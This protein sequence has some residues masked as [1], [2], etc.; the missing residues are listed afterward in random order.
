M[1]VLADSAAEPL[2]EMPPAREDEFL[3]LAC[4]PG[5]SLQLATFSLLQRHFLSV[6][7][8]AELLAG[9][10]TRAV[11]LPRHLLTGRACLLCTEGGGLEQEVR[12]HLATVHGRF[13]GERWPEY[14]SSALCR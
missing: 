9:P 10:A 12:T 6:H 5:A 13:F 2:L 11:L 8:V 1:K 7:G 4:G 3:C 14:C